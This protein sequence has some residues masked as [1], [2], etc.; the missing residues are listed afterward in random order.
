MWIQAGPNSFEIRLLYLSFDSNFVH[1]GHRI[2]TQFQMSLVDL[3][4]D[5]YIEK[6]GIQMPTL[7][8]VESDLMN[9]AKH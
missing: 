8:S 4:F 1:F 9:S 6:F 5:I 7:L 2:L 3:S